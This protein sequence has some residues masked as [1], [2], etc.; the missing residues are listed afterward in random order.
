MAA[1]HLDELTR[2][3]WDRLPLAEKFGWYYDK[4]HALIERGRPGPNLAGEQNHE[5]AREPERG[6]KKRSCTRP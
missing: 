2:E 5:P 4:T 3:A 6:W 1:F